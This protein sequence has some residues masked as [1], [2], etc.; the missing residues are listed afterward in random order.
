MLLSSCLVSN[1]SAC[2][3]FCIYRSSLDWKGPIR[4][5]PVKHVCLIG[6]FCRIS[7]VSIAEP[8]SLLVHVWTML[9]VYLLH[10]MMSQS[11]SKLI[12]GR[13]NQYTLVQK[14]KYKGLMKAVKH[15]TLTVYHNFENGRSLS[16]FFQHYCPTLQTVH[17]LHLWSYVCKW[18]A[19][20]TSTQCLD[21]NF[22]KGI[23]PFRSVY[24]Y[25]CSPTAET[26]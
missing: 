14:Y 7:A 24:K 25:K 11:Y 2:R 3:E 18:R 4:R 5:I 10:C 16:L 12:S 8:I 13:F 23:V 21:L 1:Q 17:L 20:S 9:F 22:T 19:L 6:Y 26:T 15:T